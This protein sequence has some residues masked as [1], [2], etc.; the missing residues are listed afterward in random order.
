MGGK[1]VIFV[2]VDDFGVIE[3]Q[4]RESAPGRTGIDRL[5]KPVENEDLL[6]QGGVHKTGSVAISP[7]S[8]NKFGAAIK[9]RN[10]K[11]YGIPNELIIKNGT[12]M[13]SSPGQ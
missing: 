10:T 5:P 9:V 3:A 2:T 8:S 13:V 7:R 1:Y 12:L 11:I 4:K 6:V